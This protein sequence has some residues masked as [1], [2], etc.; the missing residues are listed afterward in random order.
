MLHVPRRPGTDDDRLARL[1]EFAMSE[2][3]G[4]QAGSDVVLLRL[5]ELIF[6]VVLR[7]HLAK[8]PPDHTGWLAGLWD[9]AV[10][11]ALALMHRRA[12]HPWTLATLATGAGLSRST[13]AERFGHL[14]GL[15]PMQY[16]AR[17]RMQ[18]AARLLRDGD[19]KI[20][21]IAAQVGYES[22]AAFC[23]AFT[24]LVGVSPARWRRRRGI[25]RPSPAERHADVEASASGA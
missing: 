21:A 5:A 9:P 3:R 13:L 19:T 24:R 20:S 12:D 2:S 4:R 7:R 17:W 14:V 11:R 15:P 25:E 16:L 6:V 10:G 8:L 22:E 1:I 18:N 23:R